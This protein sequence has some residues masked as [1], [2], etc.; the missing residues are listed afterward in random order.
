MN[1]KTKEMFLELGIDENVY[2]YCSDIE[3]TLIERFSAID[4]I[5]EI[6]Q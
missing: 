1:N 4:K 5:A 3:G 6:N 2:T